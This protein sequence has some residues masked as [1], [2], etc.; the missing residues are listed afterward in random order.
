MSCLLF[1]SLL[2]FQLVTPPL[3]RRPISRL[4]DSGTGHL[5]AELALPTTLGVRRPV[6]ESTPRAQPLPLPADTSTTAGAADHPPDP[7]GVLLLRERSGQTVRRLLARP[8][9]VQVHVA[10]HVTLLQLGGKQLLPQLPTT[11]LHLELHPARGQLGAAQSTGRRPWG[12]ERLGLRNGVTVAETD[13]AALGV[14]LGVHLNGELHHRTHVKPCSRCDLLRHEHIAAVLRL[15][16]C[17]RDETVA[18]AVRLRLVALHRTAVAPRREEALD[19]GGLRLAI[20]GRRDGELDEIALLQLLGRRAKL[21]VDVALVHLLGLLARQERVA[22]LTD[23][24][25]HLAL[26]GALHCLAPSGR[27]GGGAHLVL[28][29]SRVSTRHSAD[30]VD[31]VT[32]GHAPCKLRAEGACVVDQLHDGQSPLV[33]AHRRRRSRGRGGGRGGSLV[34][35]LRRLSFLLL[36]TREDLTH[37][38]HL[39]LSLRHCG[40]LV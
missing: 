21:H 32:A 38:T 33:T 12:P 19:L 40:R 20:L 7:D 39:L 31:N 14:T 5:A 35:R 22:L 2:G 29:P 34:R 27:R 17:A 3:N 4:V 30:R 37:L 15:R 1:P 9:H 11:R 25:L 18:L 13:R 26:V 36:T 6:V 10:P 23:Q 8:V 24:H 28:D 16:L